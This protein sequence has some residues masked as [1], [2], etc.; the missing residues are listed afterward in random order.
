MLFL[1]IQGERKTY[2]ELFEA[3]QSIVG[4]LHA[5]GMNQG[6]VVAI[7][8]RRSI[9][10]IASMLG[11]LI[12]GGVVLTIDKNMPFERRKTILLSSGVNRLIYVGS[13]QPLYFLNPSYLL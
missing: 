10:L 9:G 11:V 8:G 6:E 1:N 7:Y 13:S 3:V 5:G 12:A 2:G 4:N